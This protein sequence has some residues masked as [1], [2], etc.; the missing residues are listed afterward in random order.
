MRERAIVEMIA[1]LM[2]F[3][4]SQIIEYNLIFGKRRGEVES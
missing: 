3:F 1:M 4:M 2:F